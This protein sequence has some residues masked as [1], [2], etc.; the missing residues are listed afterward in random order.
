[1]VYEFRYEITTTAML[2]MLFVFLCLQKDMTRLNKR[3]RGVVG[4]AVVVS[5]L[6]MLT[7]FL[8]MHYQEIP[9]ALNQAAN[10][11]YYASSFALVFAFKKYVNTYIEGKKNKLLAKI[12]RIADISVNAIFVLILIFNIFFG[13]IY[14]FDPVDGYKHGAAYLAVFFPIVYNIIFSVVM[15][16]VYR[17]NY[18]PW[19]IGAILAFVILL[20]TGIALQ[21]FFFENVLLTMT[22]S[23]ISLYIIYFAIESPNYY[24]MVKT[25]RELKQA[26]D[27]LNALKDS[28]EQEVDNKTRELQ[29]KTEKLGRMTIEIAESLAKTIDAKDHYT[30][31]HSARVAAYSRLIAKAAGKDAD[32]QELIY[33]AGLL[34]DIGKIGIPDSILNKPGKLDPTEMEAMRSH[35]EKGEKILNSVS[36]V[37]EFAMIAGSHHERFDGNGY[38]NKVKGTD[39]PEMARIVS[40]AD[41]FDAMTSDRSYRKALPFSMVRQELV[42]GSGTQFDP[43]FDEVFLA[44]FDKAYSPDLPYN[45]V[46][47]RLIKQK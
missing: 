14:Y 28:L 37:P 26:T 13:F 3:F 12:E 20:F 38:P 15:L 27:E 42:N 32:Y 7:A 39:I 23:A 10:F 22:T 19:Q 18:S 34:H 5:L 41:S 25:T 8:F 33:K 36:S 11:L 30:I 31:G 44:L 1:M 2:T 16:I 40:I 47:N 21:I 29:D 17:E 6:D 4:M 35:S 46:L 9:V 24:Q 45:E 43:T